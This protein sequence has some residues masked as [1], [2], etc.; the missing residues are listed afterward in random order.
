MPDP[1]KNQDFKIKPEV[2][3]KLFGN[4]SES[5][6]T[7]N[8]FAPTGFGNSQYDKDTRI[9]PE[10]FNAYNPD[11]ED[12]RAARQPFVDK[13][14]NGLA[15]F[16][17]T[18]SAG[19]LG[20]PGTFAGVFGTMQAG[21]EGK[22]DPS[23]FWDNSFTKLGDDVNKYLQENNVNYASAEERASKE[24]NP[25]A[26]DSWLTSSNFWTDTILGNA[27]Y[28][29]SAY[30]TGIGIS[31]LINKAA[32][33]LVNGTLRNVL[34]G[35]TGVAEDVAL[36]SKSFGAAAEA[37]TKESR[38]LKYF[39]RLNKGVSLAIAASGEAGM[40]AYGAY[41]EFKQNKIKEFEDLYGYS[42][43]EEQLSS[44][45]NEAKSV[46]NTVYGLNLPIIAAADIV[47][48][49]KL[50]G[51]KWESE[52]AKLSKNTFALESGESVGKYA[53]SNE[54]KRPFL[55]AVKNE[56]LVNNFSEA[57]QEGLQ[58]LASEGTKNFYMRKYDPKGVDALDNIVKSFSDAADRLFNTSEGAQNMLA[59]FFTGG[60]MPSTY[61]NI[62]SETRDK[63]RNTKQ[64][65]EILNSYDLKEN[66]KPIAENLARAASISQEQSS[67]VKRGDRKTYEDLKNDS[68]KSWVLSRIQS[69]RYDIFEE[70]LDKMSEMRKEEFA[71]FF[72]LEQDKVASVKQ[73]LNSLK[74]KGRDM[75]QAWDTIDSIYSG[76]FMN[77]S[78]SD[79]DIQEKRKS[80]EMYK[81]HVWSYMADYKDKDNRV[82]KLSQEVTNLTGKYFSANDLLNVTGDQRVNNILAQYQAIA[83]SEKLL[84]QEEDSKQ[85][86]SA[87][88]KIRKDK[89]KTLTK[90]QNVTERKTKSTQ[91]T[92]EVSFDKLLEDLDFSYVEDFRSALNNRIKNLDVEELTNSMLASGVTVN[93]FITKASDLV[94][95]AEER[96]LAL[97]SF[98]NLNKANKLEEFMNYKT[99][100]VNSNGQV[101]N[102]PDYEKMG[103]FKT[104]P[105]EQVND[106]PNDIDKEDNG[107]EAIIA[108]IST[109]KDTEDFRSKVN[110]LI[111]EGDTNNPPLSTLSVAD[112]TVLQNQYNEELEDILKDFPMTGKDINIQTQEDFDNLKN[113]RDRIKELLA[114][115]QAT[116]EAIA[117][118]VENEEINGATKKSKVNP[119]KLAAD[120]AK[121]K[122]EIKKQTIEQNSITTQT[123]PS[124]PTKEDLEAEEDSSNLVY[125]DQNYLVAAHSDIVITEDKK[126][127]KYVDGKLVIN[128]HSPLVVKRGTEDYTIE[129]GYDRNVFDPVSPDYL[130]PG[131]KIQARY[132]GDFGNEKVI[133]LYKGNSFIGFLPS[134]NNARI[135]STEQSYPDLANKL[136]AQIAEIRAGL[137]LYGSSTELNIRPDDFAISRGILFFN[138]PTDKE[139]HEFINVREAFGGED[140][141]N[142]DPKS[143]NTKGGVYLTGIKDGNFVTINPSNGS[144][145]NMDNAIQIDQSNKLRDSKYDGQIAAL[146]PTNNLKDGKRIFMPVLL[147]SENQDSDR[148]NKAITTMIDSN[149]NEQSL[150]EALLDVIT[151]PVKHQDELLQIMQ[152]LY[153]EQYKTIQ[154]Q[155]KSS[156]QILYKL[157]DSLF[158]RNEYLLS[159]LFDKIIYTDTRS[160]TKKHAKTPFG[161]TVLRAEDPN[162]P[163]K[164]RITLDIDLSRN[165]DKVKRKFRIDL[166]N[167]GQ[168][169]VNPV[170]ERVDFY[171]SNNANSNIEYVSYEDLK[172]HVKRKPYKIDLKE[173]P[174]GN[175][176]NSY[177]G[178]VIKNNKINLISYSNYINYLADTGILTTNIHGQDGINQ[179][180]FYFANQAVRF[181]VPVVSSAKPTPASV[182]STKSVFG[183]SK[184]DAANLK[185]EANKAL[186]KEV[187]PEQTPKVIN[188]KAKVTLT[189]DPVADIERRRQEELDK[190]AKERREYKTQ[191]KQTS[192]TK[193]DPDEIL[194]DGEQTIVVFETPENSESLK[195]NTVIQE[196]SLF[197][198]K[199]GVAKVVIN[200]ETGNYGIKTSLGTSWYDSKVDILVGLKRL[201]YKVAKEKERKTFPLEETINAKYDAE[202]A[203]LNPITPVDSKETTIA[204]LETQLQ[205]AKDKSQR[206]LIT[207]Y[208]KL[209][210]D[211]KKET[212][213]VP[214]P[215]K[216][217]LNDPRLAKLKA[218][219]FRDDIA[220]KLTQQANAEDKNNY[221]YY[222]TEKI[223]SLN[224]LIYKP[225][226]E[227]LDVQ[228]AMVE[229]TRKAVLKVLYNNHQNANNKGLSFNTIKQLTKDLINQD[230]AVLERQLE[231][232][233]EVEVYIAQVKLSYYDNLLFKN[234]GELD[235]FDYRD[236]KNYA[237]IKDTKKVYRDFVGFF[238]LA[239]GE[240]Y[241]SGLFKASASAEDIMEYNT[242]EQ[243]YTERF[244][245]NWAFKVNPKD[246]I[247]IKTKLFLSMLPVLERNVTTEGEVV[248]TPQLEENFDTVQF[249][250]MNGVVDHVLDITSEVQATKFYDELFGDELGDVYSNDPVIVS[251]REEL[252]KAKK[253]GE[254]LINNQLFNQ[255]ATSML[256]T[257]KKLLTIR[258]STTNKGA[259][260]NIID[261]ARVRVNN[262]IIESWIENFKSESKDLF[263][264]DINLD[265]TENTTRLNANNKDFFKSLKAKVSALLDL[266]ENSKGHYNDEVYK[267]LATIMGTFGITLSENPEES[268]SILKSLNNSMGKAKN[269]K[270]QKRLFNK[271]NPAKKTFKDFVNEIF[272]KYI[273]D[274]TISAINK[275]KFSLTQP[276]KDSGA[277]LDTWAKI[278]KPNYSKFINA[279]VTN[280]NGDSVYTYTARNYLT[281]QA[282]KL[283]DP[284]YL[285][286]LTDLPF[287][288]HNQL[289][290]N[291]IEN[292]DLRNSFDLFFLDGLKKDSWQ[293][294]S[295][296]DAEP[297]SLEFLSMLLYFNNE[298]FTGG[299][300]NLGYYMTTHADATV[301]P[302]YRFE[303]NYTDITFKSD[304]SCTVNGNTREL[305]YGIFKSELERIND[306]YN[307]YINLYNETKDYTKEE[308]TQTAHLSGLKEGYHYNIKINN[309]KTTLAPGNGVKLYLFGQKNYNN[310]DKG[311]YDS[312]GVVTNSKGDFIPYKG[313]ATDLLTGDQLND[314]A[315]RNVFDTIIDEFISDIVNSQ[316]NSLESFSEYLYTIDTMK[317]TYP[318]EQGG[319]ITEEETEFSSDVFPVK[320]VNKL[321]TVFDKFAT[322]DDGEAISYVPNL[323]RGD[324]F[325]KYMNA[326]YALNYTLFLSTWNQMHHD[327]AFYVKGTTYE[328]FFD[329]YMKRLKGDIS[330]GEMN[331]VSTDDKVNYVVFNDIAAKDIKAELTK[332]DH[333]KL[334]K[335][336]KE[337]LAFRNNYDQT[338]E[339]NKISI[340]ERYQ[341]MATIYK[342][343]KGEVTDTRL[344]QIIDQYENIKIADA[345]AY[346][347]LNE[348]LYRK[349]KDG[350]L[351]TQDVNFLRSKYSNPELNFTEKEFSKDFKLQGLKYVYSGSDISSESLSYDF[352]K[353]A[354]LPLIPALTKNKVIDQIREGLESLERSLYRD[355]DKYVVNPGV[356]A[357]P[358]SSY[359]VGS[360]KI[361]NLIGASG[362]YSGELHPDKVVQVPRENLKKQ[363]QNPIKEELYNTASSQ[364]R[365]FIH[366]DIP[367]GVR[368]AEGKFKPAEND[369]NSKSGLSNNQLINID[370]LINLNLMKRDMIDMLDELGIEEIGEGMNT[371]LIVADI[372]KF[373]DILKRESFERKG[374]DLNSIQYLQTVKDS[375]KLNIPIDFTPSNQSFES[376]ILSRFNKI[377]NGRKLPGFSFIQSSSL[378]FHDVSNQNVQAD[379]NL[380]GARLIED[381]EGN[382]T[383]YTPAEIAITWKFRDSNGK[384][385]D[386]NEYVNADGT[387]KLNKFSDEMLN[388]V[389]IRIPNTGPNS[390]GKYRVAKFLPPA[391]VDTALV[392][393]EVLAQMGSDF[394]FDKLVTYI[395]NYEVINGKLTKV[396]SVLHNS[397][398]DK[399]AILYSDENKMKYVSE[400]IVKSP[401]YIVLDKKEEALVRGIKE[402]QII[403]DREIDDLFNDLSDQDDKISTE[404]KQRFA[405]I[406]LAEAQLNKYTTYLNNNKALKQYFKEEN[407]DLS[408]LSEADANQRKQEEIDN[409]REIVSYLDDS[410]TR[411]N[412]SIDLLKDQRAELNLSMDKLD[413]ANPSEEDSELV[414]ALKELNTIQDQKSNLITST[415]DSTDFSKI[416]LYDL[417]SYEALENGI[418]DIYQ[419]M[420]DSMYIF[421]KQVNPL[422]SDWIKDQ[423]LG[424]SSTMNDNS[425]KSLSEG[426][427]FIA[428]N[429]VTSLNKNRLVNADADVII[430]IG[431][432]AQSGL[433]KAQRFNLYLKQH[434]DPQT[435]ALIFGEPILFND[436]QG[437]LKQ[438]EEFSKIAEDNKTF[439]NKTNPYIGNITQGRYRLDR[440][441]TTDNKGNKLYISEVVQSVLQAALDNQNDPI[442][443]FGNI[444]KTTVNA[445]LIASMLGYTDEIVPLINQDVIKE[446][447]NLKKIV[448]SPLYNGIYSSSTIIRQELIRKYAS[449]AGISDEVIDDTYT[450]AELN[451]DNDVRVITNLLGKPTVVSEQDL[452]NYL[453]HSSG[454]K[455]LYSDMEFARLQLSVLRDF[456]ILDTYGSQFLTYQTATSA[457]SKGLGDSSLIGVKDLNDRYNNIYK[458]TEKGVSTSVPN[459]G[460]V[461]KT[462]FSSDNYRPNPFS[463][464]HAMG[465]SKV[466]KTFTY[467]KLGIFYGISPLFNNVIE[468]TYNLLK[469]K[470]ISKKKE[471]AIN[472]K[473]FVLADPSLYT[474]LFTASEKDEAELFMANPQD[475]LLKED[476]A[477]TDNNEYD[478]KVNNKE[479]LAG[480]FN[481]VAE[482]SNSNNVPF[483]LM[484]EALTSFKT[485]AQDNNDK[486]S[487]ITYVNSNSY[488]E[489]LDYRLAKS[490]LAMYNSRNKT[491]KKLGRDL[492]LYS[493]ITGGINSPT[494]FIKFIPVEVL[495]KSNFGGRLRTALVKYTNSVQNDP[496]AL[497]SRF[498]SQFLQ[499]KGHN[500]K[501]I[502]T[503][504]NIDEYTIN[505]DEIRLTVSVESP[506][507][508]PETGFPKIISFGE[509][510]NRIIFHQDDYNE[511][512]SIPRA[513]YNTYNISEYKPTQD[514]VYSELSSNHLSPE[515]KANFEKLNKQAKSNAPV[516]QTSSDE[517]INSNVSIVKKPNTTNSVK[518]YSGFITN[519][520]DNQI[521]VFGSNPLGINGNPSKGTGGA[522]LVA[523]N[524]AGVKQGEKMDNKLSQ[525]GKAWGL[526]TVTGPGKKHSKTN[527][528][529]ITGINTLYQYANLNQDKEF[530]I[531]YDGINPNKKSLNGYTAREMAEMFSAVPIPSN[532]VFEENFSK[533]LLTNKPATS[534][535]EYIK[536]SDFKIG[537]PITIT[538]SG[539]RTSTFTTKLEN[540][541]N[542]N[543][544]TYLIE[545]NPNGSHL[546][547]YIVYEDGIINY[548]S[549]EVFAK[550]HLNKKKTTE[551]KPTYSALPDYLSNTTISEAL[552]FVNLQGSKDQGL[553][554][555]YLNDNLN[556]DITVE[557]NPDLEYAGRYNTV[558]SAIQYNPENSTRFDTPVDFFN[559]VVVHESA[560]ALTVNNIQK[561]LY[562]GTDF[563]SEQPTTQ[564]INAVTNLATIINL[565]N[566]KIENN[567]IYNSLDDKTKLVIQRGLDQIDLSNTS[568]IEHTDQ[569]IAE[570]IAN[571]FAEPDFRRV[572]NSI[573]ASKDKSFL[574]R[575]KYLILNLLN[576]EPGSSLAVSFDSIIALVEKNTEAVKEIK[577]EEITP[578]KK[579]SPF[580][581]S[582][583]I[584]RN[585]SRDLGLGNINYDMREDISSVSPED[586]WLM[587]VRSANRN[588]ATHKVYYSTEENARLAMN[589]YSQIQSVY[590]GEMKKGYHEVEYTNP[591][592]LVANP[593][594]IPN[595][596]TLN[597]KIGDCK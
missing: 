191:S 263:V 551:V 432:N 311:L 167:A 539:R 25:W 313:L 165:T 506:L 168:F 386:Y 400:K 242:S 510:K 389:G 338:F 555:T 31:K 88:R 100:E 298:E 84:S 373:I 281:N 447:V 260:I 144:F 222:D 129:S 286:Q 269:G 593:D 131:D 359:K 21:L 425:I 39:D 70:E 520:E 372:N 62:I 494:S 434:F 326:D 32:P 557:L 388:L 226:E 407:I 257:R 485:I 526:T 385:L 186:Q 541:I 375:N 208:E 223:S 99:K 143:A 202:L 9:L 190:N 316:V 66:I 566:S 201:G 197:V 95:L 453:L 10:E 306:V 103:F 79:P 17:G 423:I 134:V 448:N 590:N 572:L 287:A 6:G 547:S 231:S 109:Y 444:N 184:D 544:G 477:I 543:D 502:I 437:T 472:F 360:D 443:G 467:N 4:I 421:K 57:A 249:Y 529:I 116:K 169:F 409:I 545:Y 404:M 579:K 220:K 266:P 581:A 219:I 19:L 141:I 44:I 123:E 378:G 530:L 282:L 192:F 161:L 446:L 149:G 498:S 241:R 60:L 76:R 214:V 438:E 265:N 519:L 275:N 237:E 410:F 568:D 37:I 233:D 159:D 89:S 564:Q 331:N 499:H 271:Y 74:S 23:S 377:I 301:A 107:I 152:T 185:A 597:F 236:S 213:A 323:Q 115:L 45:E 272:T 577:K 394:D 101:Y 224:Q 250:D 267:E 528:E 365:K 363:I 27:G 148:V 193:S 112:V 376:I 398:V 278:A 561:V 414:N 240:I 117:E 454:V 34:S 436:N 20:V 48:F 145:N 72:G 411:F 366:N 55:G 256:K 594:I 158:N 274:N 489:N 314:D 138:E 273:V 67:A 91:G 504:R 125:N 106:I 380:K 157:L 475:F 558:D 312:A 189:N 147:S 465:P 12:F 13:L 153:P 517:E 433:Y 259:N 35:A 391:Y 258:M 466:V 333:A 150:P 560:H 552:N 588:A 419:T 329:N 387:P 108:D 379:S 396:E 69:G 459:I 113:N 218:G 559:A 582:N 337:F 361:I 43:N 503:P 511:Y 232:E 474:E 397:Q 280:V 120:S 82:N 239:M 200:K 137:T 75:K 482:E 406:K 188:K 346:I 262:Q 364:F 270:I 340:P 36:N 124:V 51:S 119:K 128:Y 463:V 464:A 85:K 488:K 255:F 440:I 342:T 174:V 300:R 413:E 514:I 289:I 118:K 591:N 527:S 455:V 133:G 65:A 420:L 229:Y 196:G 565:V 495:L 456:L 248:F 458:E 473:S 139:A 483:K 63:M 290:Q 493:F 247:L 592:P 497:S 521:F 471:I 264:S 416:G 554:A 518:T 142:L 309:G 403:L 327:P 132:E 126:N 234:D 291:L 253:Q 305:F 68:I 225:L 381:A 525:S 252:T 114:L 587:A 452:K 476:F 534:N 424:E 533:L 243:S 40:E 422:T 295:T 508:H 567:T 81:T 1:T 451:K 470:D 163:G 339:D 94:Q 261:S 355:S 151:D 501:N 292:E 154:E 304:N 491:V 402:R 484:Y 16:T 206:S 308:L 78:A 549:K 3:N 228:N 64:A 334:P 468:D 173:L 542:Y 586:A 187:T 254:S 26:A 362:N 439:Y 195:A 54:I 87:L 172:D 122:E 96:R 104:Q 58:F 353:N 199:N 127:S 322:Y 336:V 230:R 580:G 538:V 536:M 41:S 352:N 177:K 5:T 418:I 481:K 310:N 175:K 83:I 216:S 335:Y 399:D 77:L 374:L 431:A 198:S 15:K 297:G 180:R 59:G 136:K 317:K 42:P 535:S 428:I 302:L 140:Y 405:D 512:V 102:V 479:S 211:I 135:K 392:S 166:A 279:T 319:F 22:W 457:E 204:H 93:D 170:E 71:D 86:R 585:L 354:E 2:R 98:N 478:L 490:I 251:L 235:L 80:I 350:I 215:P 556:K 296:E 324:L 417:Q 450:A 210:N 435:G 469:R 176:K 596:L 426:D 61:Q 56:L 207:H 351:T 38:N 368:F 540:F 569:I 171:K 516:S 345:Q 330:P 442:L 105:I 294:V 349:W 73:E 570:F 445:F 532:I 578:A 370:T 486:F 576:I 408:N 130:R 461:E 563:N 356:I 595:L 24:S 28:A 30:I 574:D 244:Q 460:G 367:Y 320:F 268:W 328:S 156:D 449:E 505:D 212:P 14:G 509:G 492:I 284:D 395:Y 33:L 553:L 47:Q 496:G 277:A 430:S 11:I 146:V 49:G 46:G 500:I 18:L 550:V 245:E 515:A 194:K 50:M 383:G 8:P 315:V 348:F 412:E 221:Q 548:G 183:V 209:L 584:T 90:L 203:K 121:A 507:N 343:L 513:G 111:Y 307:K 441:Y 332:E 480:L 369:T 164:F 318:L 589:N 357:V 562:R 321:K 531:A 401:E 288:K 179:S 303:K 182:K 92:F 227:N 522:A 573:K 393:P 523:H 524:I 384:L 181:Q 97:I 344:N 276:F 390:A 52:L 341:E 537:D 429:S 546:D 571:V 29:A 162:S 160:V 382:I 371:D 583:D 462:I 575:I 246:S 7:L 358:L 487:L 285:N 299:R 155:Y 283:K 178:F 53:L 238:N 217:A 293:I 325:W 415:M 427:K 110:S 347:T 205:K